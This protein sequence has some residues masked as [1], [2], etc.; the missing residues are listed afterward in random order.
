[1]SVSQRKNAVVHR[2]SANEQLLLLRLRRGRRRIQLHYARGGAGLPRRRRIPRAQR[3]RPAGGTAVRRQSPDGKARART[4]LQPRGGAAVSRRA[5]ESVRRA[6]AGLSDR[7]A[8]ADRKDDSALRHRLR[9]RQ[10][11]FPSQPSDGEGLYGRGAEGRVSVRDFPKR[12][13]LRRVP[14]PRDLSDFRPQRRGGRLRGPPAERERRAEVRQHLR[15]ARIQE[16]QGHLRDELR[17]A[18]GGGQSDRLRGAGGRHRA[19]AGG[20][21]Q[22]RRHAGHG[23]HRRSGADDVPVRQNRLPRLRH[24]QGRAERDDEGHPAV[25]AGRRRGEGHRPRHRGEGP[26]RVHQKIR[27]RGVPPPAGRLRGTGGF[28]H[29]RDS[30]PLLAF[31]ARRKAARRRRAD[32]AGRGHILQKRARGLSRADVGKNRRVRRRAVDG[33]SAQGQKSGGKAKGRAAPADG[34]RSPRLRRQG[35]PRPAYLRHRRAAGGTAAGLYALQPR[36]GGGSLR[37]AFGG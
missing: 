31:P 29:R 20:V 16:K 30:G 36:T 6:G 10:L 28:P 19:P 2:L 3:R 24:R 7:A 4:R 26:R 11:G 15:H 34:E 33:R 23:H 5:A 25:Y 9:P 21:R 12:A 35:Q 32:H 14:Q 1:M 37:D 22:R 8:P 18:L 27:R 13:P 17:Q